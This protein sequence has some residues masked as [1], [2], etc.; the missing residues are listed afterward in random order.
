MTGIRAR[1]KSAAPQL[2]A[3]LAAAR[4]SVQ[5]MSTIRGRDVDVSLLRDVIEKTRGL[6]AKSCP[7]CGYHGRFEAFGSP[8]RWDA[9]CPSCGS[10]E[11]HRLFVL[12]LR[13]TPLKGAVLHFAPEPALAAFLRRSEIQYTSADL[14]RKDVDRNW[15]IEEIPCADEQF[16][17]VV[18]NHVLEHVNDR[19]ALRELYRI[20]KPGGLLLAMVPIVEGCA[21]TYEDES[22]TGPRN[23][24]IHFGQSD[25]V[26]VYGADF[27]QR[28]LAPGFSVTVHTAFGSDAVQYGLLMGEKLFQCQK[29]V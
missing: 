5:L 19:K 7:L 17:V 2:Y 24:E 13:A 14:L 15:N 21:E 4:K 11:R 18:C 25:H 28:L 6:S 26:R 1:L 3:Y 27:L 22:V 20:L 16:D 9:R 10:L 29:P 8:P 23:R 12:A